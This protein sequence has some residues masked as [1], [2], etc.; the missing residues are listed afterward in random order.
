MCPPHSA[1]PYIGRDSCKAHP[2][3]FADSSSPSETDTAALPREI[4]LVRHGATE[5]TKVG[6]HTGRTN[7][8]L[9]ED[10]RAEAIS[11]G[12]RLA[13]ME[14]DLVLTSPL[15]RARET[16]DLAGYGEIAD[17]VFELHEWD[18][19]E[20][21]GKTTAEIRRNWPGWSLFDNGCPRGETAADVGF[22]ADRVLE[23][24]RG[25]EQVVV[26]SHGHFLRVLAA[27]WLEM[28]PEEGRRFK[29]DPG[30]ISELGWEH[31]TAVMLFWN[32]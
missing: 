25:Y 18:Y 29:L 6:K 8:P 32:S 17:S 11:L 14:Y 16:A 10:G 31:D 4:T 5:W 15:F 30:T 13:E 26:F 3:A 21:E 24:M 9:D 28:P 7:V 22:R 12:E 2:V 1:Y 20:Y 27:R 19:G 23:S